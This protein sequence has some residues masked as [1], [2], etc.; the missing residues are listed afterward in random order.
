MIATTKGVR[1]TMKPPSFKIKSVLTVIE[2][3]I[4]G[5]VVNNTPLVQR[6]VDLHARGVDLI[7]LYERASVVDMLLDELRNYVPS[8]Q[9][10][11]DTGTMVYLDG[12]DMSFLRRA[13]KTNPIYSGITL[14]TVPKAAIMD[15]IMNHIQ[16]IMDLQTYDLLTEF[17]PGV[18]LVTKKMANGVGNLMVYSEYT[19]IYYIPVLTYMFKVNHPLRLEYSRMANGKV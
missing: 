14:P 9:D 13:A 10:W 16:T 11:G 3:V 1:F 8:Y 18:H 12:L 4:A 15:V 5:G 7:D 2:Q 6:Y 17:L 19:G